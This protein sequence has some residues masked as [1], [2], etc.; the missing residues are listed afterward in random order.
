MTSDAA[1]KRPIEKPSGPISY[2]VTRGADVWPSANKSY[3]R[4]L[5]GQMAV[6]QDYQGHDQVLVPV[7]GRNLVLPRSAWRALP[8]Y[9]R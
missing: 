8:A 7:G 2:S 1:A 5:D 3:V 9:K 6:F 4:L